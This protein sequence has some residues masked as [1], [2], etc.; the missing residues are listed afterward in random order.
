MASTTTDRQMSKQGW[1]RVWSL[2]RFELEIEWIPAA[3]Y[4][5]FTFS[6]KTPTKWGK[7]RGL[8]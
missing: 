5:T 8:L 1:Y 3:R 2:G 6:L 7:E 4:Y